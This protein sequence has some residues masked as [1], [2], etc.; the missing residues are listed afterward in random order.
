MPAMLPVSPTS[1]DEVAYESFP[2]TGTH[3]DRLSTL[4]RLMGIETPALETCRV[5]ELG[6]A[7][8]GNLVPMALQ[9]PGAQFT[10]VDLSASQ[11]AAGNALVQALRLDN[12]RLIAVD[13]MDIGDDFGQFDYII[14]HG[15]YSWVP[16]TTQEKIL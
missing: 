8:G 6:C 10:G 7:G 4:A 1:Y 12:V 5:L 15:L 16:N 14:A 3:P 13:V 9:L 2:V 11:I